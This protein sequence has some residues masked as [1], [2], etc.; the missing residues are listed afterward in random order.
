MK[1][2]IF[3]SIFLISFVML[4]YASSTINF[5]GAL[6]DVNGSPVNSSQ[7]FEFRIYKT[8]TG[9]TP[10]WTEQHFGVQINNGIFSVV[11]GQ[12]SPIPPDLL[13]NQELYL[14]YLLGGESSEMEPRRKI[15][16]VPFAMKANQTDLAKNSANSDSLGG[17][18]AS[19]YVTQD[20]TGNAS[21][22][23]TLSAGSFSGDG[24]G[25]TNIPGID[26]SLYIHSIG[27]D[28]LIANNSNPALTIKNSMGTGIVIDST[29]VLGNADGVS[30]KH[31]G[32]DAFSVDYATD[33]GV[34]ISSTGNDGIYIGNSGRFG[35]DIY[36]APMG[37]VRVSFAGVPNYFD[38]SYEKNGFEVAGAEG[39]GLFIGA[40]DDDGIMIKQAGNPAKYS[41]SSTI[42][43]LEIAGTEGNGLY[44]GYADQSGVYV[45]EAKYYGVLVDSSRLDGI[46]IRKAGYPSESYGSF[47]DHGIQIDGTSGDGL[48]LGYAEINGIY[49]NK[50]NNHG[51]VVNNVPNGNGLIISN[52]GNPSQSHQSTNKNGIEIEGAEGDGL[53]VGHTDRAGVN[54]NSAAMDGIFVYKAD[55][56]GID[57]Y[58]AG[59]PAGMLSSAL[60]N[61]IEVGGSEGHGLFVGNAD[62]NGIDVNTTNG[63]GEYGVYTPDKI[64]G[65]NLTTKTINTFAINSGTERLEA[66]DIVSLSGYA[67]SPLEDSDIPLIKVRKAG[68]DNSHAIIG[69]VDY[70][71][72]IRKETRLKKDAKSEYETEITSKSFRYSQGSASRNEYVSIVTFG[73]TDVKIDSRADIE[74]G[75]K[76]TVSK[77]SGKA[78]NIKESD[79]WTIGILGKALEN[80]YGKNKIMVYVNPK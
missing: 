80:S 3:I 79:H 77:S 33:K 18:P 52:A 44:V 51:I 26:G 15:H 8:E 59:L 39:H 32:D 27:P 54:V 17:T 30:V 38:Y 34:E 57:V 22:S 68:A 74:T 64:Y 72:Q 55:N 1:R 50:T 49:I 7:F 45:K 19:G 65:S 5:Q 71:V 43:G 40:S 14:T 76:L 46:Y 37:G 10:L 36:N 6:E 2:I 41:S 11:L 28:T 31:A 75:Q 42:N 58:Q 9:G 78:R 67:D 56:D 24:S 23:G 25:I 73:P 21:I 4:S 69:V 60:N 47:Y 48:H 16:A 12:N 53:Y 35:L 66:G 20:S 62:G 70:K 13:E 63:N 61:G 29:G